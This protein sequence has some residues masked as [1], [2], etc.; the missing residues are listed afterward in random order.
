MNYIAQIEQQ[1]EELKNRLAK[2]EAEHELMSKITHEFMNKCDSCSIERAY[3]SNKSILLV[4]NDS[5][6]FTIDLSDID[7]IIVKEL[8]SKVINTKMEYQNK[9]LESINKIINTKETSVI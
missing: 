9:L 1:N 2:L 7:V 8:M 3:V 5:T 4:K 6:S